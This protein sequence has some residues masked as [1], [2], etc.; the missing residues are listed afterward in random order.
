[1]ILTSGDSSYAPIY[2]STLGSLAAVDLERVQS[3]LRRCAYPDMRA[4][5]T[6]ILLRQLLFRPSSGMGGF[7]YGSSRGRGRYRM[8]LK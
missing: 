4:N 7:G 8:M 1:M 2:S 6:L 3:F 5:L